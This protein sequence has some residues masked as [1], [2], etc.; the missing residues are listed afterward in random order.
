MGGVGTYLWSVYWAIVS[1]STV[2]YGDIVPTNALETTFA[3][4]VIL[5]GGLILPGIVGGLAAYL[6]NLNLALRARV[7]RIALAKHFMKHYSMDDSLIKRVMNY[8]DYAWSWQG[9]IDEF[10]LNELPSPD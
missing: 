9:T 3:T 1:M 5:F 8:Y 4:V 6:S 7:Q 10:I 2:G